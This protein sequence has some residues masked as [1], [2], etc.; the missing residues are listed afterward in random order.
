ML[1]WYRRNRER[2]ARIFGF[3]HPEAFYDRP[4]PLRHP[5][6]FYAGHIPGFSF[7]TLN[8]RALGEAPIDPKIE[9]VF[10]RGQRLAVRL[11]Q[12]VEQ[13]PPGWIR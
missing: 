13:L 5:F 1:D 8:E 11:E 9:A 4:I 12:R 2:T 7:L 10:E 3:I 6:A